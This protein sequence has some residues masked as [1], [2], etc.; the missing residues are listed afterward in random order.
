MKPWI[1]LTALLGLAAMASGGCIAVGGSDRVVRTGPTLGQELTD[2]KTARDTGAVSDD[3][4]KLA[5]AQ[6]LNAG[7][8]HGH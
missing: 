7:T 1:K 5:K 3:E 2:L 8:P 6:L 4:Y